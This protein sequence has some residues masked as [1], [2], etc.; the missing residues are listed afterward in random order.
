MT[1]WSEGGALRPGTRQ[2]KAPSGI[3][4]HEPAE[5]IVRVR[6]GTTLAELQAALAAGRQQVCLE[7]G[8]PEQATVGG[9]LSVG[10]GGVRRLGWGPPRDTVLEVTAVS[11]AGEVIRSGAPLVKNVTGFDLCRLLVG[12]LGTLAL[13]GEVVLRCKPIPEAEEWWVGEVAD[14]FDVAARLYQALSVLWD[15]DRTWV[16]LSGYRVDLAA[17][18]SEV[19]GPGFA[20]AEGPPPPPGPARRSLPPGSLAAFADNPGPGGWLVEVGVGVVHC[21]ERVAASLAS[22]SL[23]SGSPPPELVRLHRDIKARFDPEGRLNPGRAVLG[24]VT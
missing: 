9:L 23:A 16:G 20:P 5:M 22:G 21:T 18:V 8:S 1:Q 19:L 15:G 14:P 17:Q 11:A 13:V 6:A 10:H 24:G 4:S 2:V 12:S 7:A 3:V